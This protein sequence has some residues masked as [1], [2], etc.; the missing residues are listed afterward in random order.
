LFPDYVKSALATA[1]SVTATIDYM[2]RQDYVRKSGVLVIGNSAGGWGAL[3][4]ASENPAAVVGVINFS[5]GRGGHNHNEAGNNCA[6]DRLVSAAAALGKSARIPTL[7]LYAANDSFFSPVLAHE[8]EAS[9]VAAGGIAK[10][11]ILPPVQGDGHALIFTAGAS[12]TW[13]SVV[14]AFLSHLPR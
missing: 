4:L 1:A 10:L 13:K 14:A 2:L 12:A 6:P 7:W 5:G 8:M 9:F 3:A 11:D